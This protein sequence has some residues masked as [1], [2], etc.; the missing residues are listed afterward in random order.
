MKKKAFFISGLGL[1]ILNALSGCA[2][3]L[4][5]A[6]VLPFSNL[7]VPSQTTPLETLVPSGTGW[8]DILKRELGLAD[9]LPST[10]ASSSKWRLLLIS[11]TRQRQIASLANDGT[12]R[13]Y[14]LYRWIKVQLIAPASSDT[15][16]IAPTFTPITLEVFRDLPY[17]ESQRTAKELE[18]NKLWQDIEQEIGQRLASR[19][20]WQTEK[21]QAVK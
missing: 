16:N 11:D 13:E 9:A 20:I 2:Y 18:E 19:I 15:Q 7:E 8:T 3:H 5:A 1:V 6:P 17:L 12:V 14:R 10:A 21:H 4:R